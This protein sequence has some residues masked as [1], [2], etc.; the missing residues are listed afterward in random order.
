MTG[1]DELGVLSK[2]LK[3]FIIVQKHYGEQKKNEK[4]Y[5]TMGFD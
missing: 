5:K 1:V 3:R 2:F 4:I